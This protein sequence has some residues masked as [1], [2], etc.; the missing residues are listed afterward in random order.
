PQGQERAGPARGRP[1]A[2][3][4]G[5]ESPGDGRAGGADRRPGG[6]PA[7]EANM[8]RRRR[9]ERLGQDAPSAGQGNWA[10]LYARG[11]EGVV[12]DGSGI[13]L[14]RAVRAVRVPVRGR[15][16]RAE[17][18]GPGGRPLAPVRLAGDTLGGAEVEAG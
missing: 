9:V 18:R 10:D 12:P 7:G 6:G 8:S 14:G 2:P 11:A 17:D 4:A 3:G 13:D 15:P 5:Y 1:G 16:R